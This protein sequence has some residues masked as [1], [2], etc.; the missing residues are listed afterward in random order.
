MLSSYHLPVYLSVCKLFEL[1]HQVL[2]LYAYVSS[3]GL[4]E[5]VDLQSLVRAFAAWAHKLGTQ[6][7]TRVQ[8]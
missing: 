3:N 2:V 1:S 8:N 4:E 5:P 6:V 7:K